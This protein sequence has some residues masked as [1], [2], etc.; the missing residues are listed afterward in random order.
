MLTATPPLRLSPR[1][2]VTFSNR[3]PVRCSSD[4]PRNCQRTSGISSVSLLIG[5]VTRVSLPRRCR[6]ARC[7]RRSCR[8]VP[9]KGCSFTGLPP[10]RHRGPLRRR[11]RFQ[12]LG[13]GLGHARNKPVGG[14][15]PL[16][17]RAHRSRLVRVVVLGATLAP[18]DPGD[19]HALGV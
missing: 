2:L 15:L 13:V 7:V 11:Q 5:M 18:A 3:N 14:E 10:S 19:R 4:S 6:L 8:L 9:T 17:Q 16:E 1:A 12:L